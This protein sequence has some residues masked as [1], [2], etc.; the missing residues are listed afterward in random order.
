VSQKRYIASFTITAKK[1]GL[2]RVTR[3]LDRMQPQCPICRGEFFSCDIRQLRVEKG[4]SSS[5]TAVPRVDMQ[6]QRLLKAIA[7]ITGGHATVEET[8]RVADQCDA[9]LDSKPDSIL[10]HNCARSFRKSTDWSFS[11]PLSGLV[12]SSCPPYWK[13]GE[14]TLISPPRGMTSAI[15]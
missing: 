14:S 13:R 7:K 3:C 6:L 8:Q 4:A 10:V 9:Y 5:T 15:A 2:R 1:T 12:T 11:T